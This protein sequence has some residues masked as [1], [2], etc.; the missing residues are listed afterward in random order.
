MNLAGKSIWRTVLVAS[1]AVF[2]FATGA[3]AADTLDVILVKASDGGTSD[4]ALKAYLPLLERSGFK[5][6]QTVVRKAVPLQA[7]DV[8]L[9]QG[10]KA[11]LGQADGRRVPVTI[12]RG[13]NNL[14]RT[15]VNFSPDHPVV[16]GTYD[17][18]DGSKMIVIL[19]LAKP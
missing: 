14:I 10:F 8:I 7:G 4:A 19:V 15:T 11:T 17:G 6:Y 18:D 9:A 13:D 12:S 5:A 1:L 3:R 2:A 16:L